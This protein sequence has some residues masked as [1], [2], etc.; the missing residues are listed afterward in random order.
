MLIEKAM[1]DVPIALVVPALIQAAY[2]L[3][4]AS[5]SGL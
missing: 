2:C 1:G 4:Q 5:R 3:I